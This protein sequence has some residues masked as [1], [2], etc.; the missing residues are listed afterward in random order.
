MI[1]LTWQSVLKYADEDTFTLITED[2]A[3]ITKLGREQRQAIEKQDWA[4]VERLNQEIINASEAPSNEKW[5]NWKRSIEMQPE[6][7]EDLE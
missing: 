5:K 3:K 7:S 1:T 4:E 2:L 6:F